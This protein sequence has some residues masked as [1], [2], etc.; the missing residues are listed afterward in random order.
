MRANADKI[1]KKAVLNAEKNVIE[2]L[3]KSIFGRINVFFT[4][5]AECNES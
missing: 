3:R 1:V 5:C 4:K 2:L